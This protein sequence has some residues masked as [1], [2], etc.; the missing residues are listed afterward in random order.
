MIRLSPIPNRAHQIQWFEWGEEPFREARN[1]NK[2][3]M[4]FLHAFWC[5]ICQ[6]MDEV[7]FSDN[8]NIALLNAYF[9]TVRAEN[10]KRPEVDIRYNQNGWPTIV[11]MTPDGELLAS[12]NGLT[13]E[14]FASL[15]V[16]VY[17]AYQNMQS[18]VPRNEGAVPQ[19]SREAMGEPDHGGP[20]E[21]SVSEITRLIMGLA[22][23][24]HGGYGRGQK[25]I[26]SEANDFLLSR[27]GATENSDYLEH[28]CLTLDRMRESPIHDHEEGG[29]YRTC[30]GED[31]SGPHREK[32]LAD[33]T[34]ILNNCLGVFQI[35]KNPSY[36]H[37]AEGII[38]Y[39][40]KKLSNSST[41]TYLGCEDF[42]RSEDKDPS[43]RGEYFSILDDC[44]Y[45][46]T[47]AETIGAY[48]EAHS[49]L[50]KSACKERALKALE[51]IWDKCW[52]PE[53]GVF[54]YFDGTPHVPGLL[55]D[56]TRVGAAFV[57]AWRATGEIE[58]LERAKELANFI[59]ARLRNPDGGYYDLSVQGPAYLRYPLTLIELNGAA[60]S[61]FFAL[62]KSAGEAKYQDAGDWALGPFTGGFSAYGIH[63]AGFGQ[64][65]TE[66]V[67]RP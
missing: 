58:Y 59:L 46:D 52:S 23:R 30:T 21:A 17:S 50:G 65:L 20:M 24:T 57:Q 61:F 14:A 56:Q 11:F 47:N 37:M 43:S 6:R 48:L 63:A 40:N 54:H 55:N 4:L 5:R 66:F 33:Q 38:D 29:Y 25:F 2:P 13:S 34:G 19:A 60:A 27:Y 9:V 36:A 18:E 3:L 31:W 28:V 45:T 32:L 41:G 35:T 15:L 67:K 39:L 62:A 10:A 51:F 53:A 16:R 44:L 7:A 1:Q 26:H 42:I 49:V 64:A 8:E 22:D 12:S